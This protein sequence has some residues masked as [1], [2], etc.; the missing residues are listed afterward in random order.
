MQPHS[1]YVYRSKEK[2]MFQD[3]RMAQA[4]AN[5]NRVILTAQA[6]LSAIHTS[7]KLYAHI[8]WSYSHSFTSL[9]SL[10][11]VTFWHTL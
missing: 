6:F 2:Q 1:S 11:P 4:Q 7:L 8:S 10:V 3:L 9:V 5:K